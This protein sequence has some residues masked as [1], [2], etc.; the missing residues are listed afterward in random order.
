MWN[1]IAFQR[2][3]RDRI[4][5]LHR[6]AARVSAIRRARATLPASETSGPSGT[7]AVTNLATCCSGSL[8]ACC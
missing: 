4:E 6:E 8:P 2:Y 7:P 5:D 3:S 1:T